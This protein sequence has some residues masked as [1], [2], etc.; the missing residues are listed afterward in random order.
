[1]PN[2]PGMLLGCSHSPVTR[3]VFPSQP[4][5]L[6]VADP[7]RQGADSQ[8]RAVS[9][10][11]RSCWHGPMRRHADAL[12]CAVFPATCTLCHTPLARL[13][14][15]PVC[16]SCWSSLSPQSGVLCPRCGEALGA[17]PFAGPD[18]APGDWLCR[19]CRVV[20]PAFDRAVAF[21]LYQGT[22][23]ELLHHLKYKGMTP[24]AVP[25][26]RLM[27]TQLAGIPG[28][29]KTLTLV[30]VP[31]FRARE[32]ERGFNQAEVLARSVARAGRTHGFTFIVEGDLLERRRSTYSQSA[33]SA[34]GRRRNLA[35][36][37][38]LKAGA[39]LR[40]QDYLLIDDIYTSGA[41]A[42]AASSV[43]RR[44]G[45]REVW[46]ATAARAQ[47]FDVVRGVYAEEIPMEE[48]VAAWGPSD[49]AQPH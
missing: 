4:S 10:V 22:L 30:P 28:L 41:T 11:L 19:P 21:G 1:M 42:R 38:A 34:A 13:S 5:L 40:G 15:A 24:V 23:R 33:L 31:L 18:R 45:A 20:P 16:L 39:T 43:L 44:A 47:R 7:Q 46:V 12:A 14:R 27:A 35:G 3:C 26:G 37:F 17:H 36:A 6:D 48:D 25:I 32:R 8:W 9:R 2:A 29:P 49:G